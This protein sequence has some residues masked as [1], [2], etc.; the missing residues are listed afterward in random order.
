MRRT[1]GIRL[2]DPADGG[3]DR[4]A[5]TLFGDADALATFFDGL[6]EVG[7]DDAIVWSLSKSLDAV[8]RIAE[9]R[10]RHLGGPG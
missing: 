7:V 4:D 8:D 6:A 9:A 3:G 5:T 1:V 2:G 10:R